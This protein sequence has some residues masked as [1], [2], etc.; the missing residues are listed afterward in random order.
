MLLFL[1]RWMTRRLLFFSSMCQQ[2]FFC[3]S[4]RAVQRGIVANAAQTECVGWIKF[5]HTMPLRCPTDGFE[6]P[7]D[8]FPLILTLMLIFKTFFYSNLE[9]ISR[10][11]KNTNIY[12]PKTFDC[13]LLTFAL[14]TGKQR[15]G[16]ISSHLM[17][18]LTWFVPS[19]VETHTSRSFFV[20]GFKLVF[21]T[22]RKFLVVRSEPIIFQFDFIWFWG[23]IWG[24]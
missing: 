21:C 18:L 22:C 11:N 4:V 2:R 23:E 16:F 10:K 8:F 5:I 12:F 19:I 9:P 6:R 15:T 7:L 13:F 24:S 14:G 3:Q 20:C 1:L 17:S